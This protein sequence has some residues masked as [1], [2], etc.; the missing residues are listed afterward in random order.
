MPLSTNPDQLI[1]TIEMTIAYSFHKSGDYI[2]DDIR[3]KISVPVEYVRGPRDGIHVIRSK[4]GEFPRKEY[5]NLQRSIQWV[6]NRESPMIYLDVF[7]DVIYAR[8]LEEGTENMEPRP[9]W[10]P[11]AEEW[12][13]LVAEDAASMIKRVF[14]GGEAT[15]D[16]ISE[17]ELSTV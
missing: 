10:L 3:Q 7:S 14:S 12:A 13:P 11:A 17:P 16:S 5:G 15:D 6:I 1:D 4:P 9:V 2:T 8:Y